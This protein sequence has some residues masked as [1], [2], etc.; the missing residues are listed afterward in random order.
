MAQRLA[1]LF[2]VVSLAA[3]LPAQSAAERAPADT[4]SSPACGV[5]G[6]LLAV[7]LLVQAHEEHQ[8]PAQI[9][10]LRTG[11]PKML[12]AARSAE[13]RR[14][15]ST[16]VRRRLAVRFAL[17]ATALERAGDAL[18]AGDLDRFWT[19]LEQTKP[20]VTAVSSLAKRAGLACTSDD[21]HGGTLTIGSP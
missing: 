19:S 8:Q 13:R 2:A 3:A 10:K 7:G 21:G 9:A 20:T 6:T 4:G 15:R 17:L 11:W 18:R 1:V 14:D 16:P 5:I 12:A